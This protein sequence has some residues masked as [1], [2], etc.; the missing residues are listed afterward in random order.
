MDE[1]VD[2]KV[3]KSY[4]NCDFI[5]N[6]LTALKKKREKKKEIIVRMKCENEN[7]CAKGKGG[8]LKESK[9]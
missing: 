7:E 6:S 8:D 9:I 1:D 4:C 3:W 5:S 2:Q